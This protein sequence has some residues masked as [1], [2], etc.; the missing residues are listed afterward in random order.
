[1]N[2]CAIPPSSE[3][4]WYRTFGIALYSAVRKSPRYTGGSSVRWCCCPHA[5]SSADDGCSITSMSIDL[6]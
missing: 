6:E 5:S 3:Q 2:M 1:M 4:L